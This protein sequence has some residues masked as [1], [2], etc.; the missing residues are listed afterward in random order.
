LWQTLTELKARDGRSIL[1]T[2]LEDGA[3]Q[4]DLEALLKLSLQ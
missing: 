3:M 4:Q 2:A 1:D